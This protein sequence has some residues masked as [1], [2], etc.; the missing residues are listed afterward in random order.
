MARIDSL[1]GSDS[2][3][4]LQSCDV[5]S[6]S[7]F[8]DGVT[9]TADAAEVGAWGCRWLLSRST[10]IHTVKISVYPWINRRN[11][12]ARAHIAMW[13]GTGSVKIWK[14]R[15]KIILDEPIFFTVHRGG[16]DDTNTMSLITT[17]ITA[18]RNTDFGIKTLKRR[19]MLY[20]IMA[21][22]VTN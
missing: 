5:D 3:S 11:N 12:G 7:Y 20:E 19:N 6:L 17:C 2:W 10:I 1:T 18:V 13:N 9:S 14:T 15:H 21:E 16:D 22:R 4:E 8:S